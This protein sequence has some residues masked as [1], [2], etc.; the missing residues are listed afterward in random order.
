MYPHAYPDAWVEQDYL[1]EELV[2]RQFYMPKEQGQ[3]PR[4]AARL[5]RLR[6]RHG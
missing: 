6:K 4:L 5:A 2:G 3:E 1:P